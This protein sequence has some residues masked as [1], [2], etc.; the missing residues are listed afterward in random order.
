[1]VWRSREVNKGNTDPILRTHYDILVVE[2]TMVDVWMMLNRVSECLAKHVMMKAAAA[3]DMRALMV[4][5][6]Y[7]LAKSEWEANS[8]CYDA[9]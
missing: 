6:I 5:E 4:S 1:M 7:Q 9:M 2:V 8:S 3:D